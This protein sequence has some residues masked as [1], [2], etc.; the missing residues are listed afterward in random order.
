MNKEI[1]ARF[2]DIDKRELTDKLTAL[3]AADKGDV[4]LTEVIFYD[5]ENKWPDEG[6]FVRIRST[7][8]TT[9]LTYKSNKA[10]TI[11]SAREIEFAVPD[12]SLAEQFLENIGLVAF[13]HQEKKRHTFELD[14]VTIDID[15]WP[16]VPTYVELEGPSEEQ[17]KSV[18]ESLDFKW[19]DAVF[20]DARAIIQDRYDIPMGTMRWF[21]FNKFE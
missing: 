6:R 15:T 3:G 16:K 12:A 1:E 18:A 2:L 9:K 11:D 5:Q 7:N 14:G 21:T 13:R 4:A 20:D 8:D 10:Q 17:I 19:E